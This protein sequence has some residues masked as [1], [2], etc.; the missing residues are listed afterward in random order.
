MCSLLAGLLVFLVVVVGNAR[1]PLTLLTNASSSFG[2]R[3][4]KLCVYAICDIVIAKAC[5]IQFPLDRLYSFLSVWRCWTYSLMGLWAN[6]PN[7]YLDM[8][9]FF[10]TSNDSFFLHLHTF[11]CHPILN[12]KIQF[13]FHPLDLK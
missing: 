7:A 1:H 8:G 13:F 2:Y 5:F 12:I 9:S 6:K 11:L 3:R 10:I 4:Q